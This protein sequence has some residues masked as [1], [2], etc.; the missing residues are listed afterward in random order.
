MDGQLKNRKWLIGAIVLTGLFVLLGSYFLFAHQNT[1]EVLWETTMA[2]SESEVSSDVASSSNSEQKEI[3][4]DIKGAVKKPGVYTLAAEA[5]LNELILLAGGFTDDAEIRQLNLA[6]K[7][8]DQQM[9]YVP[10]QE[11]LEFKVEEA[12]AANS[13]VS[14]V[15]DS[16]VNLNT[17][18]SL[19]LQQLPGVGP[20]KAQAILTYREENGPFSSV[21]DLLQISG[22]GEKTVEKL[23]GMIQF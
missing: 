23:R 19:G 18:D 1:E 5:R 13:S 16:L 2:T 6:E 10:N 15:E 12:Q 14:K 8:S 9:I 3:M 17:A 20:A 22:F 7:L 4:I 21:D 11:E